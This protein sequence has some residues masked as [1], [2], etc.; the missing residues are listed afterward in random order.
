MQ[1]DRQV[2]ERLISRKLLPAVGAVCAVTSGQRRIRSLANAM[3]VSRRHT[4]PKLRSC[5]VGG[6]AA[7]GAP[8]LAESTADTGGGVHRN[9]GSW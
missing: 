1:T 4:L 5:H 6:S 8:D 2:W 7:L 3:K 9:P